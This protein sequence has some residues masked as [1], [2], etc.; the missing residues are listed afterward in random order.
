MSRPTFAVVT[1]SGS[2][3]EV[4][5]HKTGDLM[6][7]C[8]LKPLWSRR[9]GRSGAWVLDAHHAQDIVAMLEH[10]G[11]RVRVSGVAA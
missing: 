6:R 4:A 7:G 5:G 9:A 11:Y 8:G 3:V 10:Y 1:V 2:V